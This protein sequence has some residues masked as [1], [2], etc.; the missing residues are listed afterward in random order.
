MLSIHMV[1]KMESTLNVNK[2]NNNNNI[3]QVSLYLILINQSIINVQM[4]MCMKKYF[5][6]KKI[7]RISKIINNLS[8]IIAVGIL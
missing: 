5:P 8:H 1:I 7:A 3:N 2:N 4:T 6:I